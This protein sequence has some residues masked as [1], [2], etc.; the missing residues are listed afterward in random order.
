MKKIAIFGLG[1]WI[2]YT[3]ANS[4]STN[5]FKIIGSCSDF[6]FANILEKLEFKVYESINKLVSNLDKVDY[7]I[8]SI[9]PNDRETFILENIFRK[10]IPITYLSSSLIN[11][12]LDKKNFLLYREYSERKLRSEKYIKSNFKYFNIVRCC[13]VHGFYR[14]RETRTDLLLKNIF[15]KKEIYLDFDYYQ[16]R[17]SVDDF[18]SLALD[19]VNFNKKRIFTIGTRDVLTQKEFIELLKEKLIGNGFLVKN[20]FIN[21]KENNSSVLNISSSPS[22]ECINEG[23]ELINSYSHKFLI[24]NIINE[25]NNGS[26]GI[27]SRY[28]I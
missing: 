24:D 17:C 1:S 26:S 5:G 20:K 14:R 22:I 8:Y 25:M 15:Q 28:R 18:K 11:Q 23:T 21:L 12:S 3:L 4:L 6:K 9:P 16:N 27:Y 13:S 2:G 10:N 19:L 7:A